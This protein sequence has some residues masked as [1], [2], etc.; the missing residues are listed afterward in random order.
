LDQPVQ[1]T[2]RTPHIKANS[3]KVKQVLDR[4]LVVYAVKNRQKLLTIR[5]VDGSYENNVAVFDI[6]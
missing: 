4:K 3:K 2:K 6:F 5:L 1:H